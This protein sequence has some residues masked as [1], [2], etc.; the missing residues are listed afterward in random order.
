MSFDARN[1]SSL[2]PARSVPSSQPA[3]AQ[4]QAA[5]AAAASGSVTVDM[6]PATPPP[7]VLDAVGTAA[8]AYDRLTANGVRLHFHVDDQTGDVAVHVC[9]MQGTAMG[10]LT[11]SQVLDLATPACSTDDA[12]L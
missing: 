3:R 1:A 7:E 4:A 2:H 9:D 6:V 8:K 10:S 12:G 5:P 11:S